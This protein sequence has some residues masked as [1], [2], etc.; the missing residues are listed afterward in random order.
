M[1]CPDPFPGIAPELIVR[2]AYGRSYPTADALKEAWESGAD[3]KIA[4]GPWY[5]SNRDEKLLRESFSTIRVQDLQSCV[6]VTMCL[7]GPF[8]NG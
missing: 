6:E 2:P 1:N 8:H 3:F 4:G 5:C 7:R